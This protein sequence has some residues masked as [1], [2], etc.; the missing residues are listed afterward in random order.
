MNTGYLQR[1]GAAAAI[2]GATGQ[3]VASLLEPNWGGKPAKAVEV[4][5]G[6]GFW[7][8]NLVLDLIGTFLT[9][10]ALTVV[11]GT[12]ADGFGREWARVGQLFLVLMAALG[13][14]TTATRYAMKEL[15]DSWAAAAPQSRQSYLVTFDA[16]SRL[17]EAL[18][19]AAFL[20]LGLYLAALGTAIL[21]GRVYARWIGWT[22]AASAVLVVSG[23]LLELASDAAWA[24]VLA[25]FGLFLVVAIALG[26]SMWRHAGPLSSRRSADARQ[27]RR[28][29][30]AR[31]D[32]GHV[33]P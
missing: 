28:S 23:N 7:N 26:V 20:A 12:F 3:L 10:G 14:S 13:A 1:L 32:P 25:G 29:P 8:G 27:E 16:A 9:V 31:R 18:F 30:L 19:F 17:T 6:N 33:A 4:V 24:A 11:Y 15:A 22:A 21:C 5:T 2:A